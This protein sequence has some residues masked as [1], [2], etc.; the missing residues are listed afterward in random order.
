[1]GEHFLIGQHYLW[2]EPELP[3][4]KP[5]T[6][7]KKELTSYCETEV[8][9]EWLST[10]TAKWNAH[11]FMESSIMVIKHHGQGSLCVINQYY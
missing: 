4:R 10:S 1:M 9:G 2:E 3:D 11:I 7:S 6:F 8:K 5:T